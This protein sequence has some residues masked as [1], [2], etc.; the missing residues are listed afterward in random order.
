[1]VNSIL[2]VYSLNTLTE[3]FLRQVNKKVMLN[4]KHRDWLSLRGSAAFRADAIGI[5]VDAFSGLVRRIEPGQLIASKEQN[6]SLEININ[7]QYN[8]DI[9]GTTEV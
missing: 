3:I 6:F 9:A 7:F 8:D 5:A 2:E 4:L 1:M